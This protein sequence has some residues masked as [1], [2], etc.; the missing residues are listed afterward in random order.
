ML[1]VCYFFFSCANYN[2]PFCVIFLL[3]LQLIWHIWMCIADLEGPV[4]IAGNL[5]I[6]HQIVQT[7]QTDEAFFKF[8]HIYVWAPL[9]SKRFKTWA[10]AT[11]F[12]LMGSGKLK[13]ASQNSY[14]INFNLHLSCWR[15]LQRDLCF[16]WSLNEI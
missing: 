15:D 5:G 1:N 10:A 13:D 3:S 9:L 16:S 8:P 11:V 7:F 2:I 14:R 4:L 6:V 12:D